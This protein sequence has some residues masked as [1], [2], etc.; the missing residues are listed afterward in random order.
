MKSPEM[1]WTK[2]KVNASFLDLNITHNGRRGL[3]WEPSI[4]FGWGKRREVRS[5]PIEIAQ[6][7]YMCSH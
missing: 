3:R 4:G 5:V 7:V 1:G 2:N 6:H